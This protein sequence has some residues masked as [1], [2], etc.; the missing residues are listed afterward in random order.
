MNY[1]IIITPAAKVQT[2]QA[3]DYYEETEQNLGERFLKSLEN[4]YVELKLHPQHYSFL[5]AKKDLRFVAVL[6]FPFIVVFE[7]R[8]HLVFIIAVHN[9]NQNPVKITNS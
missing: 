6:H 7:I 2:Q 4:K 8:E 1:N 5:S 3:F 9:T